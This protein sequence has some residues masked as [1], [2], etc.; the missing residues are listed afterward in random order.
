MKKTRYIEGQIAFA[1]IQAETGIHIGKLCR[2]MGI[3]EDILYLL[4][5]SVL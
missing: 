5:T 4:T 2:K 1:L 3:S